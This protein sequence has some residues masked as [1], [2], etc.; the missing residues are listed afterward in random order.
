MRGHRIRH[1]SAELEGAARSMRRDATRA[2]AVLWKALR[3]R[4]VDGMKFRR[5]RP[6]GR[7]VLDFYCAEERLV[8][9]VD[10]ESP[11]GRGERDHERDA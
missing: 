3:S 8:V 4:I 2:E 9:E 5:Q 10:G 1:A 11:D 7:F 6:V